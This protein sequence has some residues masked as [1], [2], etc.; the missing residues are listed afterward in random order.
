M[1]NLKNMS[2]I[3]NMLNKPTYIPMQNKSDSKTTL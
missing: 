3:K 1:L 2:N